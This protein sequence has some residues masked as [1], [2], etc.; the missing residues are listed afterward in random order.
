MSAATLTWTLGMYDTD[1]A[2]L[3]V[4]GDLVAFDSIPGDADPEP[5]RRVEDRLIAAAGV[6]RA[7]VDIITTP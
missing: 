7:D 4:D 6:S 5:Y 2:E 3:V 1:I